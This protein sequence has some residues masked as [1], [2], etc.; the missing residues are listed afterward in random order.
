MCDFSLH[1]VRTRDAKV[2]DKIVVTDFGTGTRGFA[3]R[4]DLGCAVCVKPGTEIAFEDDVGFLGGFLGLRKKAG[5]KTAI[6]RQVNKDKP[7]AHHD[8]VEFTD[9]KVVLLTLLEVGQRATI[10]QLPAEPK[11]EAEREDQAR[12][13]YAG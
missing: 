11:T 13:A 1:S 7:C 9:G 10:L 12:V 8:A 3:T 6:F 4:D 5:S 2:T